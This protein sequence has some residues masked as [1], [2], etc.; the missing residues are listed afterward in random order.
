[1]LSDRERS[2]GL[3]HP[4]T[5]L[6]AKMI[7]ELIIAFINAVAFSALVFYPL[8]LSGSFPLFFLTNFVTT[9]CGIGAMPCRF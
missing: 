2:D 5:Y 9:A 7:E 3:Y 1:M 8:Y 4:I 6:V